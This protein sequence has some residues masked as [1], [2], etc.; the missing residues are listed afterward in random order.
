M[1]GLGNQSVK[2]G[3]VA[4]SLIAWTGQIDMEHMQ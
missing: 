2:M 3:R 4:Q 1:T